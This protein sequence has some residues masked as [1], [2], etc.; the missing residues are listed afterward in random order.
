MK[1]IFFILLSTLITGCTH[2]EKREDNVII[3]Q[4]T[5]VDATFYPFF[6]I[7]FGK[8]EYVVFVDYEHNTEN[9]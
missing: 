5:G 7:R 4:G 8:Y 2:I 1:K 3:V 9:N 6:S